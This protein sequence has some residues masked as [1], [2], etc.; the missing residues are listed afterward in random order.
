DLLLSLD[1][2]RGQLRPRR[3]RAVPRR[4]HQT[5]P[6]A[7]PR[8]LLRGLRLRRPGCGGRLLAGGVL[9]LGAPA[10][11]RPLLLPP[12]GEGRYGGA[13]RARD[14]GHGLLRRKSRPHA[15]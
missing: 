8:P 14:G 10:G 2:V 9:P 7:P 15:L 1:P 4:G 11:T 5:L 12:P 3:A 6:V 13:R